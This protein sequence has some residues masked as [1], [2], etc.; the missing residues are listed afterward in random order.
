M[1]PARRTVVYDPELQI[2]AYRFEGLSQP[3]PDHF[4]EYY[5]I[6][7]VER[8]QR[9]LICRQQRYTVSPGSILLFAPGDSHGCT[10]RGEDALDYRGLNLSSPVMGRLARELTGRQDLPGFSRSVLQNPE[11]ACCL[12]QLHEGILT[13]SDTFDREEAL[14]LLLSMLLEDGVPPSDGPTPADREEIERV[15]DRMRSH[16]AQRLSLAQLCRWAGMSRST[17]LRCFPAAKGMTP[18]RY[19]ES[20]RVGAAREL[21]E[22]GVSP[23]EAALRTGFSDQSHFTNSF[24]RLTGLTPG[25]YRGIFAQPQKTGGTSHGA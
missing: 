21:L 3:F 14:L 16:Y 24:R 9:E 18:Y 1:E 23:I 10:Q 11:A 25:A 17:L 15:C 6:G 19:L 4:H 12:R 13:R 5:V 22:Q 8:G 20:V 2:E 7:L